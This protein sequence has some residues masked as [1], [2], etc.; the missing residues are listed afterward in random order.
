MSNDSW[1]KAMSEVDSSDRDPGLW[2]RCFA[3]NEGDEAKSRAAYI[4]ARVA[5]EVAA[6]DAAGGPKIGKCPSCGQACTLNATE[7]PHCKADFGEGAS[8]RP[9]NETPDP[10]AHP[11]VQLVKSARSRG[12]YIILGLFFGMIGVHNFYA[13]RFLP[14]ILQLLITLILGW[15]VIGLVITFIWVLI[16][17]FTVKVDG[18]GDAMT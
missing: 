18:A 9:L 10:I 2:A 12:I 14:G 8:W 15:F 5:A 16:D 4:R 1:A 13:G 7:C 11:A 6:E 17:L 3:E